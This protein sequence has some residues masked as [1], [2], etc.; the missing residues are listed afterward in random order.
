MILDSK[1]IMNTVTAYCSLPWSIPPKITVIFNIALFCS[2]IPSSKIRTPQWPPMLACYMVTKFPE[3][4]PCPS[5]FLLISLSV[6]VSLYLSFTHQCHLL[7]KWLEWNNETLS[8][9]VE[10]YFCLTDVS[11]DLFKTTY[12]FWSVASFWSAP[13]SFAFL[14]C[15]PN[16]FIGGS[17]SHWYSLLQ[18]FFYTWR[19]AGGSMREA[20]N[21]VNFRVAS[22]SR[23]GG[24]V[25]IHEQVA[26][27]ECCL[28]MEMS[29]GFIWTGRVWGL[30]RLTCLVR[31]P[32][33]IWETQ[34]TWPITYASSL[35]GLPFTLSWYYKVCL[36]DLKFW[37]KHLKKMLE[38]FSK[39]LNVFEMHE[40][41]CIHAS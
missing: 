21:S 25:F 24:Q 29:L 3:R 28:Q 33:S 16:I 38:N 19:S 11:F 41:M 1:Y 37:Y 6:Y 15:K 5:E 26:W 2:I 9:G 32:V 31:V 23:E 7:S 27:A 17:C 14:Q 39:A 12:P 30:V 8:R 22:E 4:S 10:F 18:L 20:T 13:V 35:L 40:V 34:S 36:N